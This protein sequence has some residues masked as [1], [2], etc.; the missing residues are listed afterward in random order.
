MKNNVK[1]IFQGDHLD[2]GGSKHLWSF[3]EFI[4]DYTVQQPKR[5]PSSYSPPWEPEISPSW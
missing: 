1:Y 3:G 5:Q 4:P 2:D